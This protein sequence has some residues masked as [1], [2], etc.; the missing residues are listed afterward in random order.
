MM[1]LLEIRLPRLIPSNVFEKSTLP[2]ASIMRTPALKSF[3]PRPHSPAPNPCFPDRPILLKNDKIRPSALFQRAKLILHAHHCHH[4]LT[5]TSHGL[6]NST[7]TP[8]YQVRHSLSDGT[9]CPNQCI[10]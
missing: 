7:P 9:A 6:R 10:S 3:T 5:Q 1:V 4:A 8:F 2:E